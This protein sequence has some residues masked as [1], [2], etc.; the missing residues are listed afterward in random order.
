MLT[1][2][3]QKKF[4]LYP[5]A[6]LYF[7]LVSVITFLG[8]QQSYF[9]KFATTDLSHHLHG[10]SALL[11]MLILIIQPFL[12]NSGR[13]S[14]H[15]LVGKFSYVVVPVFVVS[16]LKV[17]HIMLNSLP[18]YPP[19]VP[20]QLAMIDL[21]TV[22]M[23]VLFYVL[24]IKNRKNIQ[25]HARYMAATVL[26]VFPPGLTRFI[27]RFSITNDFDTALHLCFGMVELIFLLLIWDDKRKGMIRRPY[28]LAL[29]MIAILHFLMSFASGWEWWRNLMD[30]YARL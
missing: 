12:F 23:F 18:N 4:T 26:I 22:M 5:W 28:V 21:Y 30:A 3:T 10:T 17:I 14:L 29:L 25:Y 27:F 19:L 15:R 9:E 8:F 11:W 24:A 2:K 7:T 20:Y 13:L 6:P 1:T 16:G